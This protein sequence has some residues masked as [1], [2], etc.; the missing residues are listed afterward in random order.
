MYNK[1]SI[2]FGFRDIQDKQGLGKG[3]RWL[4]W[5]SRKLQP[6]IIYYDIRSVWFDWLGQVEFMPG[7][8]GGPLL[9]WVE[10]KESRGR[11]KSRQGKPNPAH[12]PL[13]APCP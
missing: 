13:P 4:S 1:T 9:F 7:G 3:R 11:K 2:R 12:P 10:Q 8:P 6:V 5:K